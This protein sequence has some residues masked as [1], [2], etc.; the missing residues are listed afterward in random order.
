MSV[1]PNNIDDVEDADA[2]PQNEIQDAPNVSLDEASDLDGDGTPELTVQE[3]IN[4]LSNKLP[5]GTFK[6][7]GHA[8]FAGLVDGDSFY[9]HPEGVFGCSGCIITLLPG[10][11]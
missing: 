9:A 5:K 11:N 10:M 1:S 2:D 4:A 6:T 8:R 3:A 7:I